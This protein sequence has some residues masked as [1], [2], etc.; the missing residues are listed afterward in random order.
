MS[1]R[2]RRHELEALAS[3]QH[4]VVARRQLLERG[5][6]RHEIAGMLAARRLLAIHRGAY[7]VGH[8]A[9]TARSRWMAAVLACGPGALLSHRSC[10]AL[11]GLRRTSISY[12]EVIVP[13]ERGRIAGVRPYLCR[14]LRPQDR[15]E[16]DGI[17]CTSVA[18]TLLSLGAV[19][20]RRAVERTCDE[21]EVQELFD[22]AALEDVLE[23]FRGARGTAILRA[24][25]G[26]HAIGTTLTRSELEE[27][28]LVLFARAGIPRPAVNA[29]VATPSG[30]PAEVDFLW[31]RER[32]VLETDGMRFHATRR[33]IERD[34]RKEAELVRAGYRV[35]RMTWDQIVRE[36]ATVAATLR[37][38]LAI[39]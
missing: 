2:R 39:R 34:R 9:L 11:R 16:V 35:V 1:I 17:P 14:R 27:R 10:A 8:R 24:V 18:L 19:L 5:L 21:A 37:A 29:T 36:P 7:A 6:T 30:I 20:P 4:G 13:T 22:L 15:D 3:A 33:Q 23:R 31:R 12:V 25:L 38:A 28:A 32:L 26:A